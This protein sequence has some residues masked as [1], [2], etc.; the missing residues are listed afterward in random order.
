MKLNSL[1]NYSKKSRLVIEKEL[2]ELDIQASKDIEDVDIDSSGDLDQVEFDID[3]DKEPE[4]VKT[5]NDDYSIKNV[6]DQLD[7][8]IKQWFELAQNLS[9]EKKEP[10]LKL[11][12]RL[13]ELTEILKTEF[14]NAR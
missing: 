12:D 6:S 10:F 1:S 13:S 5:V 8:M 4:E 3:S 11:G 9:A 2:D 14:L 7:G